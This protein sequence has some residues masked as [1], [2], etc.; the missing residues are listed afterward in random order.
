M[1]VRRSAAGAAT[2]ETCEARIREAAGPEFERGYA[3]GRALTLDEAV[4]IA[5][6]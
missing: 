6:A 5:L 3:E 2:G 1:P 4:S